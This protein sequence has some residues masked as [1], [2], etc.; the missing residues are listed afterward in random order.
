MKGWE[1]PKCGKV[2]APWV[3][4]CDHALS[5]GQ[6][7]VPFCG[8]VWVTDTGGARCLRCGAT[9]T[10]PPWTTTIRQPNT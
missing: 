7:S 4:S 9:R 3:E 1:C 2:F 5:I 8:H 10:T 6:P